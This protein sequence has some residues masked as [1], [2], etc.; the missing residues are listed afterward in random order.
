MVLKIFSEMIF[1]ILEDFYTTLSSD[2]EYGKLDKEYEEQKRSFTK[3]LTKEQL[4][5]FNLLQ[6]TFICKESRSDHLLYK[7]GV[8]DGINLITKVLK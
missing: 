2:E 8:G 7:K 3:E 5:K 6:E 4:E 1:H